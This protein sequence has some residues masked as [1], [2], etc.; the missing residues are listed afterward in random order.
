MNILIGLL[1]FLQLHIRVKGQT[2]GG[3]DVSDHTPIWIRDNKRNWGPKPFRFNNLWFS[4][5][6]FFSFVEKEWNSLDVKG[7]GD[8]CLVEKLK[9]LKF[10]MSLWNKEVFGWI[11]LNIEEAEKEMHFLD[12]KFAHFAGDCNTRYFHNSLKERRRRN[13]LCSL[14]SSRGVLEDVNEVKDFNFNHFKSFFED[15][16][17][18]RPNLSGLD[19]K[20][21]HVSEGLSLERPFT[22]LEIKEAIW[23]CDVNKSAGPDGYSLD[24]FKRFW[25]VI[26]VDVLKMCNYFYLK[27]SLV[28]SITSSFL[29]LIPKTNNPQSL[30]EYRPICLVGSIY[31]I[32][33]KILAARLKEVI[34]NLVST[35]QTAFVPGRNMMDGVLLVNEILDWS[36]RKKR[37]CL[38]LK[39]DFE[40]AYDSVSW[41][42]LRETLLRM[43]FGSRWMRWMDACIFNNHMSV[44]VNG[45]A[46]KEFKVQKGLRQGD[47]LSP[48]LFVL[49]MEGL[50]ALVKKSVEVG[51]FKP[52]MYG[53]NDS[54]DI[55]QFADDTIILG[56][57]SCDNIWNM[58]VILRGFEL[59]SGL[60]INFS[61]SNIIGVNVGEW[62]MNA[63]MTFLSCKK[64]VAP[65]KFLGIM[66]GDNPRRKKV[67][68]EVVNNIKRRL[69]SWKGRNISMGGRVTLINSVLNS[70]PVFTLSFFKIPGNIAKSIRK[71]QSE[72]LWSG[73]LE[74]RSIHLVKWEVVCRPKAKGGLGVRDVREM[75]KALLLKWKSRILHD[76][77]A[78]WHRF[79]KVRYACPKIRIQD[80][81][82]AFH[83]SDDSIW[84]RDMCMNN[85]L[86]NIIDNGFSGCFNCS[87]KNG[88]DVLF[89]L[90]KWLGEQPLCMEFPDLYE[91]SNW[92]H[93]T[94]AEVLVRT[95]GSVRWDFG[96]LFSAGSTHGFSN[97]TAAAS[98]PN[99][100]RFCDRIRGFTPSEN[101]CDTFSWSLDE[102]KDFT[103]ASITHAIDSAKS[104]AWDY[105]LINSL[106]VMWDLKLL[107]KIKVFAWRFFID[108]LPTREQLLKRGVDNVSSPDCVMCRSSFESSSH[109][110]FTCQEAK[111]IWKHVFIWLGIS[112]AIN[113]EE[114]ICFDVIQEKVKCCKRRI[115]INFVWVA[116]IWSIW[117]LRNAIIFKGEVF[118]F[119]VICS[120]IVFLSW[121]WMYSGYT[122]FRPTYYEWFKL[123]LS[124]TCSL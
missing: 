61:K 123:P 67:W 41:Q 72:F 95:G 12:N 96:G 79:F 75:N 73:K 48:F 70:I 54:M 104:F 45:S 100:T 120:N 86:D 38:L 5:K 82:D 34:G 40:K 99:W 112:E 58:K 30:G 36:R 69:S 110:F 7:R 11:D 43:G 29:V 78:I 124:D 115:L 80:V 52:F 97:T 108:R 19:L 113:V 85:L 46:T 121:R 18:G 2:I 103:V 84:W 83:R 105:H 64:G 8:Y 55:L 77:E 32:I 89:W 109:L 122:K 51:N 42:Y 102:D 27:G 15:S 114:I 39:V 90:N 6:D 94:V 93:C 107:P 25:S 87:C 119:D 1:E 116:T 9:A 68:L 4:H 71:I 53:E 57:A 62:Y 91:L 47:P 35:N 23:S 24:F 50:T 13:S 111:I 37:S 20:K 63:A 26:R 65:F 98:S 14:L 66:V 44:L 92:K 10:K 74:N 88:M 118:C 76:N 59:V 81:G 106:K 17:E 101:G 33:A 117:L 16:E 28:K 49:A 21:L 56:E 31:K 3:R 60:R 22:E